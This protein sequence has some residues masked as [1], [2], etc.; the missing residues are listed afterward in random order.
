MAFLWTRCPC[1]WQWTVRYFLLWHSISMPD[2]NKVPNWK[3]WQVQSKTIFWKSLWCVTPIFIRLHS[4]WR[5][6]PISSNILH[7]RCR[8]SILSLSPV[9]TCRKQVRRQ[10][11]SWLIHW[12]T[13]W[14]ICVPEQRQVSIL[15]RSLPVC[16][17]SGRLV[18]ITSWKSRRCVLPVCCGRTLWLL[19]IPN[20]C[21]IAK[22]RDL[23]VS[24]VVL[25][26][27]R[28]L[29]KHLLSIWHCLMLTLICFVH[30]QKQC[31]LHWEA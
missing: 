10:I 27:W 30:K 7:R 25:P 29:P 20:V 13:V 19:T 11:S 28:Y 1:L 31:L 17:S 14:N 24:A 8:N 26:R 15:M 18:P 16:L 12:P 22:T 6:F 2:W 9:T 4:L 5:L 3:K 21:V 23:T